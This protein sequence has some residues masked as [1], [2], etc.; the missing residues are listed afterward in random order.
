MPHSPMDLRERYDPEDIEGLLRDR[1]FDELLPEERAY[2]LRHLSGPEEYAAMRELLLQLHDKVDDGPG[3]AADPRIR[4]RVVLAYRDQRE[5]KLRI[6]LNTLAAFFMPREGAGLW[7]PAM[8]LAGLALLLVVTVALVRNFDAQQPLAEVRPTKQAASLP[9]EETASS[10][11]GPEETA[12]AADT[13]TATRDASTATLREQEQEPTAPVTLAQTGS[14]EESSVEETEAVHLA[15]AAD[16]LADREDQAVLKEEV[17]AAPAAERA[18]VPHQVTM[19]ELAR[20]MSV[21]NATG[22]VS[23]AKRERTTQGLA[24]TGTRSR[25]M[26]EDAALLDL[27]AKGW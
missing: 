3:I 15:Y 1:R 9:V 12:E 18:A 8:A 21:A 2:V 4:E 20:N 25:S 24:V 6:W 27:L 19:D 5:P 7:R 17:P 16:V 13:D 11:A 23:T 26:A 14:L 22:T 10:E